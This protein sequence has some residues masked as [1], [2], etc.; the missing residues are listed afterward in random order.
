MSIGDRVKFKASALGLSFS[1]KLGEGTICA[2]FAM[3]NENF[4]A[5]VVEW[6][7]GNDIFDTVN[8][9]LLELV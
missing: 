3:P 1:V 8:T 2:T 6:D 4:T 5:A 7:G 9:E